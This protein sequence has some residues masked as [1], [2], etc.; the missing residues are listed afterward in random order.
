MKIPQ[1]KKQMFFSLRFSI[2]A[3]VILCSSLFVIMLSHSVLV[4]RAYHK[5]NTYNEQLRDFSTQIMELDR[6]VFQMSQVTHQY[7][8]DYDQTHV[9]SYF[10]MIGMRLTPQLKALQSVTPQAPEAMA[11]TVRL[12]DQVQA[13]NVYAMRLVSTAIGL[14]EKQMVPSVRAAALTAEDAALSPQEMLDKALE[15]L[16]VADQTHAYNEFRLSLEKFELMVFEDLETLA[17]NQQEIVQTQISYQ[18]ISMILL[19]AVSIGT[20]LGMVKGILYPLESCIASVRKGEPI[21]VAGVRELR[22]MARSYNEAYSRNIESNEKLRLR[23]ERDPMT[24]LLNQ[25]SFTSRVQQLMH[26]NTKLALLMMDVDYFKHINDALGHEAGNRAL[27]KIA[28]MLM[29]SFLPDDYVVRYGGDEFVVVMLNTT[30]EDAEGL[31]EK[32]NQLNEKLQQPEDGFPPLSL[33]VGASFSEN[34]FHDELF[35]QADQAMYAVKRRGR[36]GFAVYRE[37]AAAERKDAPRQ[38]QDKP[39]LLLADDSEVNREI[40]CSML[41]DEYEVYQ[42]ANGQ[43]A[44]EEIDKKGYTLT[45]V[46]LDL[47]MPVCDGYGVL[48][49]MK[50]HRWHEVL[51]VIIISSETDPGC[52]GK[53]YDLGATDFVTRPF[54]AQI[55]RRRVRNTVDLNLKYRRMSDLLTQKIR[56]KIESYDMMLSMLG[57]IVEFRNQESGDHVL[58]IGFIVEQL[59]ECLMKKNTPYKLTREDA[60]TIRFASALHDIGKITIPDEIL[61]KPGRL[62]LEERA[63]MET[64]AAAGAGLLEQMEGFAGNALRSKAWEICRW[65]HERYDGKGYPDGLVGDAIPISAQVVSLADVYD[66][67]TSERCYKHRFS[68]EEAIRM[69]MNGE[70]GTFNPLLLDCLREIADQLPA[71][72]HKSAIDRTWNRDTSRMAEEISGMDG[73]DMSS[74]MMFQLQ[75]EQACTAFY[76]RLAGGYTFS[77]RM[78]N[79]LLLLS[80]PLAR[81]LGAE[82]M[83][84][85]PTTNESLLSHAGKAEL[86]WLSLRSSS[87]P[88][89]P[90]RIIDVT[91][92][93]GGQKRS[94]HCHI[95]TIWSAEET[96]QFLGLV[97]SLIPA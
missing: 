45:A 91:Y 38:E 18:F 53:A 55:V 51:P 52:I 78:D 68:H 10:D 40:L 16:C 11:D 23:A 79:D 39:R 65:H 49:Y 5:V 6:T 12:L 66:A 90:D 92:G 22:D 97:G 69:I 19:L 44:I 64:H 58:H 4:T 15:M 89:H 8:H 62:T 35:Q 54:D 21:Q 42:V 56:E 94:Y 37:D 27:K 75:F 76:K 7:I 96:P 93:E 28:A 84:H 95:H 43:Q 26:N 41:E 83:V 77:Y 72:L 80:P 86:S 24:G 73:M 47:M 50:K 32:I 2:S 31:K 67:L 1:S 74:K 3:I 63:I 36:C 61:N 30:K 9:D 29:D 20:C 85:S 46:L 25:D 59:L 33:S 57:Q 60:E 81:M 13:E 87:S 70:C 82:E 14:E 34:G 88:E 48:A 17:K 71:K